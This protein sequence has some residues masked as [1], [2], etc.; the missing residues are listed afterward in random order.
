MSPGN[1][2]RLSTVSIAV[3]PWAALLTE[4]GRVCIHVGGGGGDAVGGD[5]PLGHYLFLELSGI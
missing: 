1:R 4:G 3:C 2:R 5:V